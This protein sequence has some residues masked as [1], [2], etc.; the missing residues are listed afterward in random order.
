[1]KPTKPIS[2]YS[3]KENQNKTKQNIQR[4]IIIKLTNTSE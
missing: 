4:H 3:E 2:K 1:M